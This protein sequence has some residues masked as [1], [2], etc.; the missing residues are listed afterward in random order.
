V[1]TSLTVPTRVTVEPVSQSLVAAVQ[2]PQ[3]L[4]PGAASES[5]RLISL[6]FDWHDFGFSIFG[7]K[8]IECLGHEEL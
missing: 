5:A 6:L 1:I 2:C 3:K 4:H 7:E 8:V